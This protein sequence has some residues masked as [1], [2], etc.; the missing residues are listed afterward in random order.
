MYLLVYLFAACVCAIA[1]GTCMTCDTEDIMCSPSSLLFRSALYRAQ[2]SGVV[3]IHPARPRTTEPKFKTHVD[4]VQF[5][6][7]AD[8][9][10]TG[11]ATNL[12]VCIPLP[13]SLL[14]SVG[15]VKLIKSTQHN[16]GPIEC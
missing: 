9:A 7:T 13:S 14:S 8:V 1:D 12:T 4:C 5:Y 16:A 15:A 3:Q 6:V 10:A 2:A 11:L